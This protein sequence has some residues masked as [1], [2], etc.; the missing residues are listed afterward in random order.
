MSKETVKLDSRIMKFL[1]LE[2]ASNSDFKSFED[3]LKANLPM[4]NFKKKY[5]KLIRE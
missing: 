5:S 3:V 1:R 2:K 4:D